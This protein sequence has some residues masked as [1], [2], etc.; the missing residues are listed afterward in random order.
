[1]FSNSLQQ[2]PTEVA[3]TLTSKWN[4]TSTKGKVMALPHKSEED[5]KEASADSL[6]H[7]CH[8]TPGWCHCSILRKYWPVGCADMK[9][10]AATGATPDTRLCATT[11]TPGHQV[12]SSSGRKFCACVA[13]PYEL[14]LQV[15]R[16][17]FGR[18]P[19]EFEKESGAL[20]KSL[21]QGGISGQL[22][23]GLK[24]CRCALCP[25]SGSL[26]RTEGSASH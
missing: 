1:M 26:P 17:L 10:A 6:W 20:R 2:E 5:L 18:A 14:P 4:S 24:A 25:F 8:C 15:T 9:F 7:C 16:D 21:P 3:E 13:P 23:A 22:Q 12:R 11:R 19:E